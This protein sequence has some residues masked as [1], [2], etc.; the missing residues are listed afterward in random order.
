MTQLHER[1]DFPTSFWTSRYAIALLVI[2]GVAAY[3]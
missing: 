1:Q 3:F 2:C